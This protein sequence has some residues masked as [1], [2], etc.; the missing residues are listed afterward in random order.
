MMMIQR[1]LTES[2]EAP[3]SRSSPRGESF[4]HHSASAT[5]FPF[6]QQ[7]SLQ[8]RSKVGV[9]SLSLSVT[10]RWE[11]GEERHPQNHMAR[12][13]AHWRAGAPRVGGRGPI[14]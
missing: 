11:A 8:M 2:G 7:H 9:A 3:G 6:C 13:G 4:R 12:E 1:R 14:I 10:L 5:V